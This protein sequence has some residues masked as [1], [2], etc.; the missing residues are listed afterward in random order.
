[1]KIQQQNITKTSLKVLPSQVTSL[2]VFDFKK[3]IAE[4]LLV[5][6]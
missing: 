5:L 3:T 2:G 1:M 4:V 6:P